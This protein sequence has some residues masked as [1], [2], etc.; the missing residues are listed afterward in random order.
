MAAASTPKQLHT[1]LPC[2]TT[3]SG[4]WHRGAAAAGVGLRG[5]FL[6]QQRL[7]PGFRAG[8]ARQQQAVQQ[9]VR[10]SRRTRMLRRWPRLSA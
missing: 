6:Q 7:E 8:V 9:H 1:C 3:A 2:A 4:A 10:P 5:L